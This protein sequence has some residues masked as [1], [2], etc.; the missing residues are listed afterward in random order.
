MHDEGAE[1]G[2]SSSAER[3]NEGEDVVHLG[4][5]W[6]IEGS[7]TA[8]R[9]EIDQLKTL[10]DERLRARLADLELRWRKELEAILPPSLAT[11][12]HALLDWAGMPQ[13]SA[14][15]LRLGLAQLEGWVDGVIAGTGFVVVE[16]SRQ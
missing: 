12:L 4:E 11:E 7:L 15:E 16:P 6:R 9:A 3:R 2:R 1:R 14:S 10:D 5:L 8:V 13:A